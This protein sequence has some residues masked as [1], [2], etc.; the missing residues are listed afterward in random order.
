[1]ALIK[2]KKSIYVYAQVDD[3]DYERLSKYKWHDNGNGYIRA[4]VSGKGKAQVHAMLHRMIMD[5]GNGLEVD[6]LNH[7][8]YD[9]RK[10]NL[11][12]CSRKENSNN[13]AEKL[14]IINPDPIGVVEKKR[15]VS[16]KFKSKSAFGKFLELNGITGTEIAKTSGMSL[17]QIQK[18]I[19]GISSPKRGFRLWFCG[20]YNADMNVFVSGNSG[21]ASNN[22]IDEQEF[23]FSPIEAEKN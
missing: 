1:M 16:K 9:N 17:A 14:R 21:M 12:I 7:N 3:E 11:R 5:A 2:V 18:Y 15:I 13:R 4:W 8:T 23:S 10:K 20:T 6:H 22:F 19:Y